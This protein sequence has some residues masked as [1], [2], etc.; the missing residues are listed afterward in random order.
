MKPIYLLYLPDIPQFCIANGGH[1]Q[2]PGTDGKLTNR[3]KRILH[4][5][6]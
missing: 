2:R 1:I 3:R 6:L 4:F 5:N